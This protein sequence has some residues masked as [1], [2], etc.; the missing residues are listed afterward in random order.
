[1][2]IYKT[3]GTWNSLILDVISISKEHSG[4]EL[5]D[6]TYIFAINTILTPFKSKKTF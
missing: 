5:I 1:M 2:I 6:R 4:F 3:G